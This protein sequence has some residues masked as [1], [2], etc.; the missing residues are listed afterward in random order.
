VRGNVQGLRAVARATA[1]YRPWTDGPERRWPGWARLP[2]RIPFVLVYLAISWLL[3]IPLA[4]PDP[5]GYRIDPE[6]VRDFVYHIPDLIDDRA[7]FLRSLA[8]ATFLNHNSVQLLY[9]T[10]LLLSFGVAFEYHEGSGR[11]ALV[12][13]SATLSGA[14]FAGILLHLLYPELVAGAFFDRAWSRTWSGGSAGSFGLMGALAARA[15]RP[16]LLLAL[17]VL[18]EAAVAALYLKEYTSAFHLPALFTG[19]F[20]AR[21]LMPRVTRVAQTSTVGTVGPT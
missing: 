11:T 7:R 13:F 17:F 6:A 5:E 3:F 15:R 19:Y 2:A 18:W 4:E 16:W 9:V 21:R 10:V 1:P 8:T 14:L 20:I 12:F